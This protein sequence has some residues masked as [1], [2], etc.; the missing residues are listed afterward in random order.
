MRQEN[1]SNKVLF[2]A[3]H[4]FDAKPVGY[5]NE[6]VSFNIFG[7]NISSDENNEESRN[8]IEEAGNEP[9]DSEEGRNN[10]ELNVKPEFTINAAFFIGIELIVKTVEQ[11]DEQK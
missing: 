9:G 3:E 11:K 6:E 8:S 5:E 7:A 10:S 1:A 4:S 2:S